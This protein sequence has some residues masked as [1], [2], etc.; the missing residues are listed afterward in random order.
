MRQEIANSRKGT[1]SGGNQVWENENE[2]TSPPSTMGIH[3]GEARIFTK[4][5]TTLP[6]EGNKKSAGTKAQ[7][8]H[9]VL[10][11]ENPI[12][13]NTIGGGNEL[14]G[15]TGTMAAPKAGQQQ[16]AGGGGIQ[17]GQC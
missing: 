16:G 7:A 11:G 14:G 9:M 2:L 10:M 5:A 13:K 17:D 4:Q 12:L 3:R 15:V 6:E 8:L 1:L